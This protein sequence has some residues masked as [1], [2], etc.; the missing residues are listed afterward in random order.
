M[1]IYKFGRWIEC[2][3]PLYSGVQYI[4]KLK[5]TSKKGFIARNTGEIN[6][7][8]LPVKSRAHKTG[9]SEMSENTVR[10]GEFETYEFKVVM[11]SQDLAKF[12]A[13][14]RSSVKGRR[15]L[16]ASL[17]Q[18]EGTFE[19][20]KS[21]NS[22]VNEIFAVY[23]KSL[24]V[25]INFKDEC[26]TINEYDDSKLKEFHLGKETLICTE[27]DFYKESMRA[28]IEDEVLAELGVVDDAT[29]QEEVEKR[30]K[31]KME[32]TIG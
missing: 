3:N 30:F 17:L 15:D 18:D 28:E 5:Q 27:W 19:F 29:F 23:L 10:F 7:E 11:P 22:R 13:L 26:S 24:G 4:M 6:M 20:D 32:T 12:F 1:F 8:G 21:Y 16:A 25:E 31:I 14:Y 2:M 9:R